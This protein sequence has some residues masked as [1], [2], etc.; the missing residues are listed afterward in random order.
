MTNFLFQMD[1]PKKI[2]I[3]EDSTYLIIKEAISRGIKCFYNNPEW[4]FSDLKKVTKIKSKVYEIFLKKDNRLSYTIDNHKEI[5]LDKF[6][7]IFV[8]QDPPFNL[9][10]ISNTY[11]LDQLT[12]PLII[13]NPR[14][15]RNYPEKHIMMNF[16][17]L[18]PATLISSELESIIRFINKHEVVVI[19][20][21]YGNGGLGIEKIKKDKKNLRNYIKNYINNFF[22][23]PIIVQKF[24]NNF[25]KGDKRIILINGKVKGAVLRLPKKNSIKANFH[26]GGSAIKTSLSLKE[27]LICKKLRKFLINNKLYFVGID[28]IDG[29]LT[30]INITSPTGIQEINK[31][32]GVKIE[33]DIID[34]ALKSL[35]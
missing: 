1:D 3:N 19:K 14:E 29:H 32:N 8:R 16:P 22:K 34:F 31:L 23:S 26:A 25:D 30:E 11:L 33:K 35:K 4:V 18:T 13:N 6:D 17:E 15:I 24:L 2:N 10:Y 28:V 12:K 9:Q 21:A 7:V 27:K 5:N 20:P